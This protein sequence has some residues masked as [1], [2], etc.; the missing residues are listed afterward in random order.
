LFVGSNGT[1]LEQ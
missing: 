1:Q